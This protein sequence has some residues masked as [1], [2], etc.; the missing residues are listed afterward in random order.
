MYSHIS[1]FRGW[2][3]QLLCH[4]IKLLIV[5]LLKRSKENVNYCNELFGGNSVENRRKRAANTRQCICKGSVI[6]TAR[7]ARS[8]QVRQ[9]RV[10][11]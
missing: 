10:I 3:H 8:R 9:G 5:A 11:D 2:I 4:Q 1:L 7:E 6:I